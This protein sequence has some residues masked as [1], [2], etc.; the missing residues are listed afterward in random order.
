M[1]KIAIVTRKMITGGVERALIAMLKQF[2]YREVQVDLYLESMGGELFEDIPPNVNCIQIPTLKGIEYI[3][4]PVYSARKAISFL[5]L[6]FGK[7]SYID[8]C[9]LSSK[10]LLPVKGKYDIAISYHAPNTIPVFYAIDGICADK[11]ILWLHGDLSEN[12]G[13]S[14]VAILYHGKYDKVFAVSEYVKNSFL[15]YHPNK[16]QDTEVFYNYVD[17]EQIKKKAE[18]GS[19]Y[20]DCF[21]GMRILTIGRLD[22]QKGLDLAI[23]A[24]KYLVDLKYKIRWYV[25]GNGPERE[26]LEK[27]IHE[28]RLNDSFIL[29]GN[30]ENPY[31]YL[32]DCD[33][34][35]QP[36]RA[37]GYCTTTN[38]A[39]ILF[40]P[41]I[42]TNVSGASE[43]FENGYT[44]WIVQID[45]YEIAE[46][47]C[48]CISK[49]DEMK[50]VSNTL[51]N[52]NSKTEFEIERITKIV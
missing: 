7:H 31:R 38:E 3:K 35:V 44:G 26:N 40:K 25:C 29:L 47:I 15:K 32:K 5:K 17:V 43:Q 20:S 36:S 28:Q 12:S 49:P 9:Y 33:L 52:L 2:N 22:K 46:K 19:T 4:H 30:Q 27:L 16:I 13:D 23:K 45:E 34:Y 21:D 42:T 48:Y 24:C 6:K 37:E 8:Q 51:R 14:K 39:K 11:K 1:K 50:K 18:T 10:M 41:V